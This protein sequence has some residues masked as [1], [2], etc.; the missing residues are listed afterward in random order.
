MEFVILPPAATSIMTGGARHR[1]V[2]G[3]RKGEERRGGG[4]GSWFL[5]RSLQSVGTLHV[6]FS[7][8]CSPSSLILFHAR[9]H[10]H[11]LELE[12]TNLLLPG[13]LYPLQEMQFPVSG[14]ALAVHASC[15]LPKTASKSSLGQE[16]RASAGQGAPREASGSESLDCCWT[17]DQGDCRVTSGKAEVRR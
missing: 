3:C 16:S 10:V 2:L 12:K 11:Q 7:S 1:R 9:L 6:G 15:C 5:A 14:A 8:Q 13:T 4:E 17:A